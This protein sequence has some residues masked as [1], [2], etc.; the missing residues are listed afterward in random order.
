MK[1]Q[2][3]EILKTLKRGRKLTALKAL[4]QFGSLCFRDRI[5]ELRKAG[6]DIQKKMI[7]GNGKTWAE[8]SLR[9]VK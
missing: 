7:R 3:S 6:H 1:T 4:H 5:Y 2:N 8:Y 9:A